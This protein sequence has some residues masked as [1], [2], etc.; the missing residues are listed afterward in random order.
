[1]KNPAADI[2][3]RQ[4]RKIQLLSFIVAVAAYLAFAF[5]LYHIYFR[6]L[7]QIRLQDFFLFNTSF[8]A[9]GTFLLCK[10][11]VRPWPGCLIGGAIYG[12]GPYMFSLTSH[13]PVMAFVASMIPWLLLPAALASKKHRGLAWLVAILPFA[14]LIG[15]FQLTAHLRVFNPSLQTGLIA[16][17]FWAIVA[18]LPKFAHSLQAVGFYHIALAAML[19]GL[20]MLLASKRYGII[21]LLVSGAVFSSARPLLNVSPIIWYSITA[22]CCSVLAAAGIEGMAYTGGSDKKYVLIIMAIMLVLAGLSMAFAAR[23]GD[24]IAGLGGRYEQLFITGTIAYLLAAVTC[25][26]VFLLA[27]ANWRLKWLRWAMLIGVIGLDIFYGAVFIVDH[28]F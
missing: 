8:A 16:D 6:G 15:F 3:Y 21:L 13:H 9:S 23:F 28:L 4:N 5:Y 10:R 11:W 14:A 22:V 1:M 12:F 25:G 7:G 26:L 17:D 2:F 20:F 18:P 27:K 24:I 19:M